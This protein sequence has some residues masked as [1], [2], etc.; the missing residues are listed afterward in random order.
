MGFSGAA[1]PL[2]EPIAFDFALGQFRLVRLGE[3]RSHTPEAPEGAPQGLTAYLDF[4]P[5]LF[6]DHAI[7]FLKFFLRLFKFPF[8]RIFTEFRPN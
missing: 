5:M 7:S 2:A 3:Q 6:Q 1:W 8:C 4:F